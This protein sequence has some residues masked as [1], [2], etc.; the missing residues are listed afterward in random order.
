MGIDQLLQQAMERQQA[1]DL[2]TAR[3]LYGEALA[4]D[5]RNAVALIRSGLLEMQE[6]HAQAA[7]N[8]IEQAIAAKPGDPRYEFVLGEVL[9]SVARWE[10]AAAA[11]QRSVELDPLRADVRF[12]QGRA[13]QSAG[14]L[15]GAIDAYR[16]AAELQADLADAFNNIGNCHQLLGDLGQAE[17]AYRQTLSLRPSDA[18]AMSNLGTV[19]QATNRLDEAVTLLRAAANLEPAAPGHVVNLGAALCAQRQ[20]A[21]AAQLLTGVI[22]REANN[23]EGAYNQGNALLGLGRVREAI[24]HYQTAVRLRPGYADAFNNLGNAFRELG[25]FGLAREAYEE[26]IRTRPKS[27]VAMNNLGCL[28][29]TVG[30]MEEA[31][32]MLRRGLRLEANH[33]ALH[34]NLANVLKDSGALDEAIESFRRAITLDPA[35][36]EAHSN[37]AYALSFREADGRPVL[38]EC[39]R[40]N[41]RHAEPL[42]QLSGASRGSRAPEPASPGHYRTPFESPHRRLRIGYVSPDFRDHCQ[43]LFTIPLLS[44]HDHTAFEIFCYSSVERPDRYT[45]RIA[46]YANTWREVRTLD[47]S[48]LCDV[49]RGDG[50]DVL[51][52]LTMHMANG[53][54]LVFARR[55]APVQLAWLAYPGTTGMAAMD[56]RLSDPRLDPPESENH[57]TE[58]T[59]R[60]PDSFWCYDP[61]TREPR[62]NPL[63]AASRGH[64]TFG[65]LNNPCKLTD[66]TLRLFGTVLRAVPQSRLVLMAPTGSHRE[67]LR[68]RLLDFAVGEDRVEFVPH[69]P[70]S[71]YLRTY[72]RIDI[73]LDTFPYN[74]HTTS[75]DALWMGVPVVTRIGQTCVG[76]GGLSQLFQLDLVELAGESDDAFVRAAVALASD[77]PRLAGLRGQLRARMERSP[78]MDA[79]RFAANI[80]RIYRSVVAPH[81]HAGLPIGAAHSN[82]GV[83]TISDFNAT[84]G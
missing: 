76:R 54:P 48:A 33:P 10:E 29:R 65:C 68:Q 61:L 39:S 73:G 41:A 11:Y 18:G 28:L 16:A 14:D 67:R 32:A 5:P 13:L 15:A 64:V 37:L 82:D 26:A 49:I 36:A 84:R 21:E 42:A 60:L 44:H 53:R 3:R 59:I 23:A 72:Q 22:E 74:G 43:S 2:S 47:D 12:A 20:Y 1:A 78:L 25:E 50:I 6:G 31:E 27:V 77:L 52:D 8:R 38:E 51:V 30:K 4:L 62:V 58:R 24:R 79:K 66:H 19:L 34:N 55:A 81:V 75:L 63:P 56:Y 70:R 69:R 71:E 7:I 17:T 80:E 40:W 83:L 9:A 46:G 57:Y 35:N 45:A